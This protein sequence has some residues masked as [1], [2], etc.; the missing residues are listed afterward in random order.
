MP[1]LRG[2]DAVPGHGQCIRDADQH[3]RG[4]R[5][6]GG[7][8]CSAQPRRLARGR[9]HRVR[10]DLAREQLTESKLFF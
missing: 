9:A 7:T 5:R 1:T 6:H 4:D 2:P 10:T 8:P 3:V